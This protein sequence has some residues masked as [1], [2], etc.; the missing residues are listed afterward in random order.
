MDIQKEG[1]F[2]DLTVKPF[3]KKNLPSRVENFIPRPKDLQQ[4]LKLIQSKNR[5]I[6]I[7][8][9]SDIGKSTLARELI[10][11]VQFRNLCKDGVIYLDIRSFEKMRKI[12]EAFN[13]ELFENS[14]CSPVRLNKTF[15]E[16]VQRIVKEL[17][18]REVLIVLDSCQ[19]IMLSEDKT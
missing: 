1:D 4:I 5:F 2:R 10:R 3:Y 15:G 16:N 8:G 12:F 19:N 6:T 14:T 17:F 7:V 18:N 13:L 11:Y 9:C